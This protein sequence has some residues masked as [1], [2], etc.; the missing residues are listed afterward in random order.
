MYGAGNVCHPVPVLYATPEPLTVDASRRC[1]F[2]DPLPLVHDDR[3]AIQRRVIAEF[4]I[5][6]SEFI[7]NMTELNAR[8]RNNVDYVLLWVLLGDEH[9][10]RHTSYS[11][12]LSNGIRVQ[13]KMPAKR[14]PALQ[15]NDRARLWGNVLGCSDNRID[16]N[17]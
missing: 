4:S 15:I 17:A 11:R 2:P 3:I 13:A 16:L 10:L 9:F 6:I 12:I 5:L 1:I 7:F 14:L 8:S